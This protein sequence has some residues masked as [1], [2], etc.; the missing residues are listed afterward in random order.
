MARSFVAVVA[1]IILM[2]HMSYAGTLPGGY[3]CQLVA[4][5]D[6]SV[7]CQVRASSVGARRPNPSSMLPSYI[8]I[9]C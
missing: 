6:V 3:A 7:S 4:G 1:T 2:A 8:I 5:L 9:M